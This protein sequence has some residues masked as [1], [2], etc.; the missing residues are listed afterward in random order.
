MSVALVARDLIF[1]S[2]ILAAAAPRIPVFRC[3]DPSQLP[4][5]FGIDLVLVDW[6]ERQPGWATALTDWVAAAP[7]PHR[8]RV[9]LYGP[10]TDLAAHAE[11]RAAG[12]GP[13]WARSRILREL[14]SLLARA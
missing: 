13:M 2:R 4:P 11:A 7:A 12:L 1:G 3:D 6:S 14:P 8:P 10:H 5:P 9:I